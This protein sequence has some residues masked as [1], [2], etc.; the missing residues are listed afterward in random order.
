MGKINTV[1]KYGGSDG[2][3]KLMSYKQYAILILLLGALLRLSFLSSLPGGLHY[4]EST[5][6]FRAQNILNFGKDEYGRTLPFI[7]ANWQEME[8]PLPTYLTLPFLALSQ[9]SIFLLRLPYGILGILGILGTI[10]LTRKLFPGRENLSLFAG[11]LV[12]VNPW[13]VWLSRTVNP[14]IVAFGLIIWGLYFLFN[15]NKYSYLG[16]FLIFLSLFTAKN[17][18]LFTAPFSVV[19]FFWVRDFKKLLLVYMGIAVVVLMLFVFPGFLA[20]FK[21]NDFSIF[22]KSSVL[23]SINLLRG[24]NLALGVPSVIGSIFFNK[25]F[26]LIL[27]FKNFLSYFNPSYL[28]AKGDGGSLN[29]LS[30]FGPLFLSL[31]PIFVLGLY[32]VFNHKEKNMILL[33]IWIMLSTLPGLFITDAPDTKRYIMALYPLSTVIAFGFLHLK[34]RVLVLVLILVFFNLAVVS[35]D[36]LNKENGR[37]IKVFH[38]ETVNLAYELSNNILGKDLILNRYSQKIE[39]IWLTDSIDP[40]PGPTVGFLL[41]TPYT[42]T[43]LPENKANIYK[44]WIS[45]IGDVSIGNTDVLKENPEMFDL[46]IKSSE[47]DELYNCTT[48]RDE[49]WGGGVS[50][51]LAI[52]RCFEKKL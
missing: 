30:N 19:L 35:F 6:G 48:L 31:F 38:P 18:I 23:S 47:Q 3:I 36:A 13:G 26:F 2:M 7:F 44:G 34:K 21:D 42:Q 15:K 24:Q 39:K 46:V 10:L 28:F 25:L 4:T 1:I 16:A 43:N 37:S 27:I 41:E 9:S 33:L 45:R 51:Y 32:K 17:L 52:E 50:K 40:N 12:A 14:E 5:L 22:F 20:S 8:M 11:F 29:G 49:F